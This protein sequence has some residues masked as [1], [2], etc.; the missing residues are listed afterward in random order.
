MKDERKTLI[1]LG[2][3]DDKYIT[4]AEQA[5]ASKAAPKEF[6]K[7]RR[8]RTAALISAAV[9]LVLLLTAALWL[10]L[11]LKA[12][13]PDVSK[14]KGSDYYDL[15]S[16]INVQNYRKDHPDEA[17]F[18]NNYEKYL[19]SGKQKVKLQYVSTETDKDNSGKGPTAGLP[20]EEG[21][22]YFEVTDNQTEGV[23]EADMFKRSGKYLFYLSDHDLL[24]YE[25]AGADTKLAGSLRVIDEEYID[26]TEG[27]YL[28]EDCT[29]VTLI[30]SATQLDENHHKIRPFGEYTVICSVDVSDPANMKKTGKLKIEGESYTSRMVDGKLTLILSDDEKDWQ[31]INFDDP[32]SFVPVMDDGESI[33]CL[34]SDRIHAYGQMYYIY[35]IVCRIDESTLELEDSIAVLSETDPE[36]IYMTEDSLYLSGSYFDESGDYSVLKS[37]IAEISL[38]GEKFGF[39]GSALVDGYA[40]DKF[41]FDEYN[42]VLRAVMTVQ[43]P[44]IVE[45]DVSYTLVDNASIYCF[46]A[47]DMTLLSSVE[48]FAPDGEVVRSARFEG[49]TAY[50]CTSTTLVAVDP[51]YYF[52]LSDP[53]NI[54]SIDT[55][56]IPGFSTSLISLGNG[57][58]L[59]IGRGRN[60]TLG[61]YTPAFKVAIYKDV[62]D[63]VEEVCSYE[64]A[65]SYS[66]NYKG[67]YID[68][69]NGV[70][71]FAFTTDKWFPWH[72]GEDDPE[73]VEVP[74]K[75][76]F[77]ETPVYVLLHFDGEKFEESVIPLSDSF[78]QGGYYYLR[79]TV[80]DGKL[81]VLNNDQILVIAPEFTK[82]IDHQRLSRIPNFG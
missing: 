47:N 8:G 56:A 3:I 13:Y 45:K 58:L 54:T 22:T 77:E 28:S 73:P 19:K 80:I 42:G 29:K 30:Y 75:S 4:E 39:I 14:Y 82:A 34:P 72:D 62:G 32:A 36:H 35:T 27:F 26:Y 52:D 78:R 59:G 33:K 70:F 44:V 25:I 7:R 79:A 74:D 18:I 40:K 53:N 67:Y 63:K 1:D 2:G 55:G 37:N 5:I 66:E 69:E 57:Y 12:P 20:D 10:F 49:K 31:N 48:N 23:I 81:Y 15:I 6:S 46:D 64:L 65:G 17:I 51:V 24:A 61:R 68:R 71:G 38:D 9:V 76:P 21:Q 50:V 43:N 16:A 41:C 60:L 11:P